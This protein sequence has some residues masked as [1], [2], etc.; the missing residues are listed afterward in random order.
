MAP[1]RFLLLHGGA[2]HLNPDSGYGPW[3]GMRAWCEDPRVTLT[4]R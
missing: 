2:G 4:G 3:P 1:N